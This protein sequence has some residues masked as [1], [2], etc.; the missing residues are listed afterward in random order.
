MLSVDTGFEPSRNGFSFANFGVAVSPDGS[1]KYAGGSCAGMT[2]IAGW[3]FNK[4]KGAG[5]PDASSKFRDDD[6]FNTRAFLAHMQTSAPDFPLTALSVDNPLAAL[7][8]YQ[9]LWRENIPVLVNASVANGHSHFVLVY[10]FDAISRTYYFYDPNYPGTPGSFTATSLGTI[11]GFK[12]LGEP[13]FRFSAM[14]P[15]GSKFPSNEEFLDRFNRWSQSTATNPYSATTW[16]IVRDLREQTVGTGAS[17]VHQVSGK[18]SLPAA[19]SGKNLHAHFVAPD[20][21]FASALTQAEPLSEHG[22]RLQNPENSGAAALVGS[23]GSFSADILQSKFRNDAVVPLRIYV[24]L[25][26]GLTQSP[27]HGLWAYGSIKIPVAVTP[28]TANRPPTASFTPSASSAAVGAAIAFNASASVDAD[29]SIASYVWRFGDG[30]TGTGVNPSHAY[31][32]VGSYSITLTVTDNSG[33]V[34]SSV[35][36]VNITAT[37]QPDLIPSAVI[38]TPASVQPGGV[39][40]V[41]WQMANSGNASAAAS[42][43]GLRLL[44]G[45]TTGSGAAAD[46]LL[47]VPT[48]ALAAGGVANQSQTLTIPAGTAPGSYVVVVVADNVVTSTLGQSN[49]ANDYARSGAFTVAS[50]LP[51]PTPTTPPVLGTGNLNDTGITPSQ[52]YGAEW[53]AGWHDRA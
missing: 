51:T 29:G 11:S 4:F 19:L 43:T 50:S 41:A 38:V 17:A 44:S 15:Y 32:S 37:P 3:Y 45:A 10:K 22:V 7:S 31:T 47:N 42:T 39:V 30:A 14:L 53:Q 34:A 8:I 35:R 28:V 20:T 9:L 23:D 13:A 26:N 12:V 21:V 5:V 24:S 40:T 1:T 33:A 16:G 48:G 18:V 49:V 46:N 6:S 36:V 27:M 52:C 2:A 25:S